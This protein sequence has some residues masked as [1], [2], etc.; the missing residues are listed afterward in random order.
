MEE[1]E[2]KPKIRFKGFTEAWEQRKFKS[3]YSNIRNAF[4]GTATPYYVSEGHFYL[5]SNNVKDGQINRNAEIFINDNFYQKQKDKWLHTGDIVMVQSGHVG[6]TAVIPEKLNNLAAHAL[7]MFSNQ[8][9]KHNPYFINYQAQNAKFKKKI[10]DIT[11]GNT[12][13]HILSSDMKDF[14]IDITTIEEENKISRLL[15]NIDNLI[16]LHQRKYDKLI[17]VKK[18]LLE[19]MFPKNDSNVPEIRFKGFTEAWEQ[20]KLGECVLIQ[21]G[22]SPRPIEK[23]ITKQE[24]GVN[25]IK[26]GDVSIDSR[27][28]TKTEE[29]I[30]FEGVKYSRKVKI[31]DLILSN[32]MSFGRPYIMAI[33]GCIHDGWLLIRNDKNIFDLEYLLQLFSSDYMYKQYQSLASGGVVNNLNSELVQSTIALVPNKSEQ[34]K[35]G[36]IFKQLDNLI[37]LHQHKLDKLKNIK[38]SLLE[39]MFI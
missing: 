8:I 35:I 34:L 37:T 3:I 16:T 4:V 12:I 25:W 20:R 24:N 1:K 26:I 27:Y 32:S 38:K 13:K 23:F 19:K 33:N 28:I 31:G 21:R 17:N 6:H 10:S 29:K 2:K 11:T 18:S 15:L 7:I 9:E 14:V 36:K 5:E 39:K 30:I 22:G